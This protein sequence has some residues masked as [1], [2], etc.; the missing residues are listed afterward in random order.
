MLGPISFLIYINDI[1]NI[2]DHKCITFA[3]DISII[4]TSNRINNTITDHENDI[5]DT[6]N[7]LIEWLDINNLKINLNK[8][9]YMHFN[10]YKDLQSN[11]IHIHY[12]NTKSDEVK[13]IKLL[14][15]TIDRNINWKAHIYNICSRINRFVYALR[16]VKTVTN[17]KT[18]ITAYHAYV[19][20][21]L[22]YGLI[23]WG[24]GTD[25][26]KAFVAQK[27]CLRA[28]CDLSPRSTCRPWFKTHSLLT[29]TSLYI[30]EVCI[31]VK[32]NNDLFKKAFHIIPE[33]P[34][35][36]IDWF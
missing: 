11:L 5:N 16:Q 27:K 17:V 34:E 19:G 30:Y 24:N 14:G 36:R 32:Q 25:I 1:T 22:R 28:I 2:T 23:M 8:S 20:S 15:L 29:L 9:N 33:I 26:N 6:L 13:Q 18:A 10:N 4:V 7:K 21:I 12:K 35:I 31:F 3:D